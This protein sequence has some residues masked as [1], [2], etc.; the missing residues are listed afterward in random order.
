MM[1]HLSLFFLTCLTLSSLC[2][3]ESFYGL[4]QALLSAKG[5]STATKVLLRDIAPI[6]GVRMD[7][8]RVNRDTL[9]ANAMARLSLAYALH[10]DGEYTLSTQL[11]NRVISYFYDHQDT[12]QATSSL[13]LQSANLLQIGLIA[14]A[15]PLI[16]KAKM[17]A[18][19]AKDSLQEI[20]SL[21]M[22]GQLY[23]LGKKPEASLV[24]TNEGIS[25][26]KQAKSPAR[27]RL[28]A[29]LICL[30]CQAYLA[31]NRAAECI[32]PLG[33][34]SRLSDE[35]HLQRLRVKTRRLFGD[36]Y[37][38]QER[39][40]RA[41]QYYL[42]ALYLS[43]IE[44]Q[45]TERISVLRQLGEL[46][47]AQGRILD[48]L[49][50]NERALALADSLHLAGDR[51]ELL[52]QRYNLSREE[53]PK[54]ALYNLE[55][56]IALRDSL[57]YNIVHTKLDI[58]HDRYEQQLRDKQ[59]EMQQLQLERDKYVKFFMLSG[60]LL[61]LAL[62]G[63]L[64]FFI[65]LRR[66]KFQNMERD[67]LAKNQ[68]FSLV[69]HDT[70]NYALSIQV[71]LRQ[72]SDHYQTMSKAQICE[73]L[74][75][76][77]NAADMQMEFL[78]NLL[79]W[80]RLQLNAVR[81]APSEF[82]VVG[83]LE[84]NL[85]SV[86][87]ALKNKELSG[88]VIGDPQTRLFADRDMVDVIVRNLL[89]NAI[90]FSPRGGGIDLVVEQVRGGVRLSVQDHGAGM[91]EEQIRKIGYLEERLLN[92][93]SKGQQGAGLGLVLCRIFAQKN[94]GEL[95]VDSQLGKGTCMSVTFRRVANA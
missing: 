64:L 6:Y 57:E 88:R 11:C 24:Y 48:A 92:T 21:R 40:P 28:L 45:Y 93:G 36:V 76:L 71:A 37:L 17:I 32:L 22:L 29:E 62:V 78:T 2:A 14:D 72:L 49:N 59:F 52:W 91:T 27:D 30:Q 68:L 34:G 1:R 25:H 83:L 3:K 61:L 41:E 90:K 77:N 58:Q 84:R 73:Y 80:S 26:C 18:S 43:Q 69:S 55:H 70:K 7:T 75:E 42:E 16:I 81:Y 19:V 38:A 54:E 23:L 12:L 87:L 53:N 65:R 85:S 47:Q 67:V 66:K 33:E 56:Y 4:Y 15:F 35:Q 86:E 8:M 89:S 63:L 82:A 46:R 13:L 31:L 79:A 60:I 10:E 95:G 94:G 44:Q 20:H 50:Y 9:Y 5:R 74:Y 51:R 39:Y